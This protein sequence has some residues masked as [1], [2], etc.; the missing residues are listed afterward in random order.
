MCIRSQGPALNMLPE[1]CRVG[2]CL[3]RLRA[4]SFNH[5]RKRKLSEV[6][7]SLF[8]TEFN[9]DLLHCCTHMLEGYQSALNC[10]VELTL[11]VFNIVDSLHSCHRY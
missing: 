1:Y 9:I 11:K 4:S 5:R 8:A 10:A 7:L 3:T 2:F 6:H